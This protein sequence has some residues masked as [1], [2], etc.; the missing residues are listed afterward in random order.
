MA[1]RASWRQVGLVLSPPPAVRT[2]RATATNLASWRHFSSTCELK[3]E[4]RPD[5]FHLI[6]GGASSR[7]PGVAINDLSRSPEIIIISSGSRI[8]RV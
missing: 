3:R 4:P 6:G 7:R 5:Q 1:R 8:L 2:A